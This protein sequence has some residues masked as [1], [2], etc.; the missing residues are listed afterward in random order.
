MN[1]ICLIFDRL[2]VGYLGPY[3]NSWIET[4]AWNRLASQSM[5]FDQALIDSPDLERLYRSYWQGW[6]AMCPAPPA[7]RPSL[8]ALMRDVGV[9]SALLS[10]EPQVVRHPLAGDFDESVD[11]DP[12][13]E[14][15]V[16]GDVAGTHFGRCFVRMIDWLQSARG[17]F[18][19][20]CH[21]SGLGTTWDVPLRFRQAYQDQGDPD[22]PQSAE[23][24][25]ACSPPITIPTRCWEQCKPMPGK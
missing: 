15:R 22:P 12:P 11:I 8:A 21:L 23:V 25:D 9:T 13:W 3:G 24:P 14:P 10:D 4:P 2:H 5:V 16:A 18:L 6:H 17:P 19:L 1:A 20:W 7:E